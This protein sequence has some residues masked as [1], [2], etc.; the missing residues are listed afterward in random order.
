MPNHFLILHPDLARLPPTVDLVASCGKIGLIGPP[1]AEGI[2]RYQAG[3]EYL[4][5]VTYLGCS[6]HIRLG[7]DLDHHSAAWIQL[8]NPLPA[9]RL[10]HGANTRAPRCR[11]CGGRLE[12]WRAARPGDVAC[13]DC[14]TPWEGLDWR[15]GA[16]FVHQAVALHGIF[17]GEAVPS[18]RL[19]A[20]LRETTGVDWDYFYWRGEGQPPA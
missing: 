15:R 9:P 6:P 11:A 4:H 5:L 17:E 3:P 7:G 18:E 16:A 19:M 10:I 2:R 1:L 14:R 20:G 8:D 12:D 13:A